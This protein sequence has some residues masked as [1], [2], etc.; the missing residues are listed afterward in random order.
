MVSITSDPVLMLKV[1]ISNFRDVTFFTIMP[2]TNKHIT[3]GSES[4]YEQ[5]KSTRLSLFDQ[6]MLFQN[7]YSK[8]T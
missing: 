8:I 1:Y 7:F 5:M 2:I 3:F 4:S 6:N